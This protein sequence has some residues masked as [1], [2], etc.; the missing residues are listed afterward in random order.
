M[1][2][3]KIIKGIAFSLLI[4]SITCIKIYSDTYTH[5]DFYESKN[6]IKA[7]GENNVEGYIFLDDLYNTENQPQNPQEA[8]AYM[9]MREK[10]AKQYRTISLYDSDK[11][12][13]IGEYKIDF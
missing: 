2:K 1:L 9:N 4:T 5:K 6:M 10:S 12:T 8:I 3:N 7:V 13:K 11:I